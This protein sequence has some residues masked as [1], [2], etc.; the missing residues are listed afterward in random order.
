MVKR[1][2]LTEIDIIDMIFEEMSLK[3]S[4]GIPRDARCIFDDG[5]KRL[6]YEN[7][8]GKWAYNHEVEKTIFEPYSINK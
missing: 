4:L 6:V 8:I 3:D 5:K 1:R 2:T 7:E